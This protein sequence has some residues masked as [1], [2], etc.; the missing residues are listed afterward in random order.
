MTFIG[1][2]FALV[3]LPVVFRPLIKKWID[4]LEAEERKAQVQD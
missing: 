1:V 2:T 3:S 4:K